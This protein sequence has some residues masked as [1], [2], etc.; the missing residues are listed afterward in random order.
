[1]RRVELSQPADS[2]TVTVSDAKGNVVR[3]L[4]L[5][6]QDTGVVNFQWDGKDNSGTTLADGPYTNSAPRRCWAEPRAL[7]RR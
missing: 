1:M 6:A 2:V 5:G 4:Q 7:R 3:T